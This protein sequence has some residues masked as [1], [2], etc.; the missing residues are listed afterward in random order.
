MTIG[1]WLATREPA[2]PDVLSQRLRARL[3]M[4][5]EAD[6]REAPDRFLAAAARVVGELLQEERT[7]R[8]SAGDLLTADALVTYAFE[9]ASEEPAGLTERARRAMAELTRLGT[10]R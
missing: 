2:P 9:A 3:G 4:D 5:V 1:E 6:V 7:G 8:E 10:P